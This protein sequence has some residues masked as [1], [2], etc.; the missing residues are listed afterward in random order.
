MVT[1]C[2][3]IPCPAPLV[4]HSVWFQFQYFEV[5]TGFLGILPVLLTWV[6]PVFC[7]NVILPASRIHYLPS[8]K[9]CLCVIV[10]TIEATNVTGG[11][12]RSPHGKLMKI[13]DFSISRCCKWVA[14][15][16]DHF[17]WPWVRRHYQAC[18]SWSPAIMWS[19]MRLTAFPF[20]PSLST[21]PLSQKRWV[22]WSDNIMM[23][24]HA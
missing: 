11:V 2:L 14:K 7:I 1:A 3:H 24:F 20:I 5:G 18:C 23:H 17:C 8:T 10:P 13:T 12:Y 21:V 6:A 4:F 22:T 15:S 9:L 19:P 16:L